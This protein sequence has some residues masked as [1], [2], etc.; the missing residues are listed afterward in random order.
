MVVNWSLFK[1]SYLEV[2]NCQSSLLK[3]I[4]TKVFEWNVGA[5]SFFQNTLQAVAVK[6]TVYKKQTF[7][8]LYFLRQHL[9]DSYIN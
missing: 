3:S 7:T 6:K 8:I 4:A 9:F 5:Y 2:M 1:K